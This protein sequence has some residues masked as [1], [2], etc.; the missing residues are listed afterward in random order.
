[1]QVFKKAL[2][3]LNK[4]WLRANVNKKKYAVWAGLLYKKSI[5]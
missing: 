4:N 3:I 5:A 1:M 2:Q